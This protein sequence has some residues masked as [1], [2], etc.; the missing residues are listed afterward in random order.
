MEWRLSG[1]KIEMLVTIPVG[2]SAFEANTPARAN[3]ALIAMTR[4]AWPAG[5]LFTWRIFERERGGQLVLLASASE[6]GGEGF[7]RDGT[8]GAPLTIRLTWPVDKDKDRIRAEV[9]ALLEFQSDVTVSF[10]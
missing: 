8:P 5:P 7:F 2:P 6:D 4:I 3:G 9:D 10:E 1:R